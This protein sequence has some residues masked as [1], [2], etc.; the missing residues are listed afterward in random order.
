[1]S[2]FD[3]FKKKQLKPAIRSNVFEQPPQPEEQANNPRLA[4]ILDYLKAQTAVPAYR[5]LFDAESETG[6]FDSKLGGVPYWNA[7]MPYPTDANGNA[8]Y[9]LLQLNLD[10][11]QLDDERLPQGGMLQVFI[12]SLDEDNCRVIYHPL[13][14]ETA[15]PPG[16]IPVI[17]CDDSVPVLREAAVRLEAFEDVIS[18]SCYHFDAAWKEAV[19]AVTGE[20]LGDTE[21]TDYLS[22]ADRD[23]VFQNFGGEGSK[24]FGYPIFTQWDPREEGT[25]YPVMLL[26]IDSDLKD[27]I[28]MWG[29]C[30]EGNFFIGEEALAAHHFD[31]ILYY[32]DCC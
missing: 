13:I 10:A 2:L 30:G 4:E 1:M 3:W 9:L 8:L 14:D 25:P 24:L 17:P 19:A 6:I 15:M 12:S 27:R 23:T 32:W 7:A 22:D 20:E 5:L 18:T 28:T 29:D 31:D 16:D 21:W 26:Q 11:L